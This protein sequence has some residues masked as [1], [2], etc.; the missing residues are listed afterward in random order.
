M[1]KQ[2]KFG[3]DARE[4]LKEGAGMLFILPKEKI[5]P[6]WMKGMN[7]PLDFVWIRNNKAVAI[8][9]NIEHPETAGRVIQIAPAEPVK[10]VLE[11]NAGKINKCGLEVGDRIEIDPVN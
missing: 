2:L 7:F 5:Q 4:N 3:H 8:H 1:A 10:Y 11:L 6:F 9:T